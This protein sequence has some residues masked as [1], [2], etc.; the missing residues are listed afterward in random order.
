MTEERAEDNSQVP[1]SGLGAMDGALGIPGPGDPG[2]PA[3]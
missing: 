2:W 3:D 1:S